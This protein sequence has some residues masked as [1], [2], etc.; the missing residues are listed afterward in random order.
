MNLAM[1]LAQRTAIV[2]SEVQR[3]VLGEPAIFPEL[4]DQAREEGLVPR[5]AGVLQAA[6]AAQLPV[7]HGVALRRA[8]GAG[9]SVNARLFAA[10]AKSGVQLEIGSPAAEVLPELFDVNDLVSSRLHG[11]GPFAGTDL[12]SVLRNL[13]IETVVVVGASVNVAIINLVMDLVNGGYQV[14]LPT[15]GVTGIPRSYADAVIV[16]TLALLATTTT[17]EDLVATWIP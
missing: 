7:V 3:G 1:L 13:G 10:A 9:A 14:V 5:L 8:D 17:C 4:A 6:R 15:D 11:L 12:D 16:N 2:T